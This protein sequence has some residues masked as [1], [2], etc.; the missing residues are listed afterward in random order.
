[1]SAN[2]NKCTN[3][4]FKNPYKKKSDIVNIIT[5]L[6]ALGFIPFFNNY[7]YLTVTTVML[8][9][10]NILSTLVVNKLVRILLMIIFLAILAVCFMK[11]FQTPS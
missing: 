6:I 1:M 4:I 7:P 5:V 8:I 3:M 10:A 2:N 11:G 9:Y